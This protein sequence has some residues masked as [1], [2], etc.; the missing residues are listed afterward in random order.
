MER[1]RAMK[2]MW[3]GVLALAIAASAEA[4]ATKKQEKQYCGPGTRTVK[5]GPAVN[6]SCRRH[7][8][9]YAKNPGWQR[10][11]PGFGNR[12][13]Q[14]ADRA[15]ADDMKRLRESGTLSTRDKVTSMVVEKYFRDKGRVDRAA[16]RLRGRK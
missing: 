9:A 13:V 8:E 5:T 15:L 12:D 2:T 16:D 14:A 6:D 1:R 7:D 10:Y 11:T 3:T 4:Q